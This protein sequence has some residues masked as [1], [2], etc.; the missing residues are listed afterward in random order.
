MTEPGEGS[1]RDEEDRLAWASAGASV[2]L[3]I[4]QNGL[5]LT[6]GQAGVMKRPG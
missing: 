5:F 4:S 2:P 3:L 1:H 6:L